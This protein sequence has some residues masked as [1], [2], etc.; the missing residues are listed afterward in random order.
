[1]L[2]RVPRP[3]HPNRARPAHG[4]PRGSRSADARRGIYRQAVSPFP[5]RTFG[6]AARVNRLPP[7]QGHDPGRSE[8]DPKS[9]LRDVT[10]VVRPYGNPLPLGFFSFGIGMVVLA[11]IALG[12]V[13]DGQ[14]AS[15]GVLLSVFVFP[16]EL[17]AAI[18]AYLARDTGAATALGLFATSWAGLGAL[19]ILDPAQQRSTAVGLYLAAFALMLLPLAAVGLL[20][21][22]LLGAVLSVSSLRAALAAAYQL[23]AP[24]DFQLANGAVAFVL[25]A[26]AFYAGTAF[27]LEDVRQSTILPILRRG[28]ARQAVEGDLTEQHSRVPNEPGVR[29]QL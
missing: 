28:D 15:A 27:L 19:H 11:G 22:A 29:K 7:D 1:M 16:L 2:R 25:V 17:L 3:G 5:P 20:G 13:G 21:K 10:V 26:L 9:G 18:L 24:Q 6:Y 23:G 14:V 12:I 8:D 4:S